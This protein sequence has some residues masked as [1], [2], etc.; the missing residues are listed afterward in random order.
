MHRSRVILMVAIISV[1][2]ESVWSQGYK[3]RYFDTRG[4]AELIRLTFA[5]LGLPYTDIRVK[6]SEWAEMKPSKY[7]EC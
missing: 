2:F 4:R 1:T 5:A 6:K 3:L 7:L